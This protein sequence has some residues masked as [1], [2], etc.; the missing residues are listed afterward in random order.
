[1]ADDV[2]RRPPLPGRAVLVAGTRTD[3]FNTVLPEVPV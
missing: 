2:D 3:I 1:M